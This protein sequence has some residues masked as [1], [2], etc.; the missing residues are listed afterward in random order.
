MVYKTKADRSTIP[1]VNLMLIAN[2]YNIILILGDY[3][4]LGGFGLGD[5]VLAVYGMD[6]K[7]VE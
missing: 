3:V 1:H 7:F 2:S 4:L 6:N 5:E